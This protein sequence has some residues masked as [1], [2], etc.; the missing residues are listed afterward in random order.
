MY[1]KHHYQRDMWRAWQ[2]AKPQFKKG[3]ASPFRVAFFKKPSYPEELGNWLMMLVF[4][5][6]FLVQLFFYS[7]RLMLG[8]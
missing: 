3:V 8:K 7:I 2:K 6:L 1:T 4:I 5:P